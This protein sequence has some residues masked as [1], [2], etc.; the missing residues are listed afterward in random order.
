MSFAATEVCMSQHNFCHDKSRNKHIFAA[1]KHSCDNFCHDKVVVTSILLS[2][3]TFV[4][5]KLVK[6]IMFVATCHNKH[7]F[8]MTKHHFCCDV[9]TNTGQSVWCRMQ[10]W[11]VRG[12]MCN[13]LHLCVSCFVLFCCDKCAR[14]D[15]TLSRQYPVFVPTNT[16]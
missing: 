15:K 16:G 7:F 13:M 5:S 3:H 9:A 11:C 6:T 8:V 4:M 12:A 2:Q 10:L 1:A 14:H